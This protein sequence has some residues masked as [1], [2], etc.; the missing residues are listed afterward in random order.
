VTISVH[1]VTTAT[2]SRMTSWPAIF[3][4]PELKELGTAWSGSGSCHGSGDYK[5]VVAGRASGSRHIERVEPAV[6]HDCMYIFAC[7]CVCVCVCVLCVCVARELVA[8]RTGSTRCGT[9]RPYCVQARRARNVEE[10]GEQEIER[11]VCGCGCT[12]LHRMAC[13]LKDW[14]YPHR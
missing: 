1:K 5:G 3:M 9:C 10:R 7:V 13:C 12:L 14:L 2:R 4:P 6:L 11:G 8:N